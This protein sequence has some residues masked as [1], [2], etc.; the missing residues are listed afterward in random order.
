MD[1][2]ELITVYKEQIQYLEDIMPDN[3]KYVKEFENFK[4]FCPNIYLQG[5]SCK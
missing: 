2:E 4:D 5:I 1:F 3:S